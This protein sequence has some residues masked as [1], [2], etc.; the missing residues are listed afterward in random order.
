MPLPSGL[1]IAGLI[2]AGAVTVAW[3]VVV[4]YGLFALIERVL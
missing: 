2:I 4:G 3:T 1:A